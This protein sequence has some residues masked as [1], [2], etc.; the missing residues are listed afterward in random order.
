VSLLKKFVPLATVVVAMCQFS[1]ASAL[2]LTLDDTQGHVVTVVDDGANDMLATNGILS[3]VGA[4]GTWIQNVSTG[5][6]Y[7]ILGEVEIDLN[8]VNISGGPGT[9]VLTLE[10][11]NFTPAS[12]SGI[13]RFII[14][15]GGTTNGV[16]S[17]S[18][19]FDASNTV[20]VLGT[21]IGVL[22]PFASGM[23]GEFS[24]GMLTNDVA[25]TGPFGLAVQVTITHAAAFQISSFDFNIVEVPDP[26]IPTDVA[27]PASLGLFA[28][29]LIGAGLMA[30]GRRKV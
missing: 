26:G 5:V 28:L 29:G 21:Q 14:G 8:S 6:S 27:E 9:L 20:G 4:V 2:V 30:R 3:F 17:A 25:Y 10:D 12:L 1:Q 7:P 23:G 22:G 13:T 16:L 11:E 18:A 24:E 15:L 19:Y